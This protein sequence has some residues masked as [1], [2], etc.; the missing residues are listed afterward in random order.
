MET[1]SNENRDRETIEELRHQLEIEQK[2]RES[3]QKLGNLYYDMWMKAE[4]NTAGKNKNIR[5]DLE[6]SLIFIFETEDHNQAKNL[7][8]QEI[9]QRG[10]NYRNNLYAFIL[11]RCQAKEFSE[12]HKANKKS[13]T[14]EGGFQKCMK[15]INIHVTEIN[16]NQGKVNPSLN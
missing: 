4:D 13:L 8:D 14:A 15:I 1:G 9:I 10:V 7:T 2:L 11:A 16:A 5:R 6:E 12:W 3:F